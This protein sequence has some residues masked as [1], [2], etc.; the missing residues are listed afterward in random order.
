METEKNISTA[1]QHLTILMIGLMLEAEIFATEP[2]F[3][4]EKVKE[5]NGVSIK[6]K[7]I[8]ELNS[9]NVKVDESI[10]YDDLIT[11]VNQV[12]NLVDAAIVLHEIKN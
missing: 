5:T 10:S 2:E 9:L 3:I 7:C 1:A 12:I 4:E 8:E 6:A 11:K